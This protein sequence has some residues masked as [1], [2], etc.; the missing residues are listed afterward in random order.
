MHDANSIRA[1]VRRRLK[2][3]RRGLSPTDRAARAQRIAAALQRARVVRPGQRI[4]VYNPINGEVELDPIVDWARAL[5]C[6]LYLPRIVSWSRRRMKFVRWTKRSLLRPHRFGMVEPITGPAV[7]ARCLDVVLLPA[8]AVDS[9]GVRLGMGAGF[10]DRS[11]AHRRH[12]RW[13]R[14]RLIAVVYDFQ[15]VPE[16]PSQPFDVPV[17]AVVSEDGLQWFSTQD[18]GRCV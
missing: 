16:L 18:H 3:Q 12:T 13:R 6:V 5:G 9:R 15:R 1:D 2:V 4:A 7:P 14:P 10:Y 11:F 17:D 8:V